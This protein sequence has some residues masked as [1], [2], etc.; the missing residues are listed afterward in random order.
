VNRHHVINQ[1]PVRDYFQVKLGGCNNVCAPLSELPRG[2]RL[3][4][5]VKW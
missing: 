1:E 5:M 3:G 4:E 2:D